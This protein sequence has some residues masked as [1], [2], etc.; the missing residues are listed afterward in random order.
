MK[1]VLI[2]SNSAGLVSDFLENDI[3]ILKNMG[4]EIDCACNML[5]KGKNSDYFFKYYGVK[6]I[7]ISFPIRN[8]EIKN[9]IKTY[10]KLRIVLDGTKYDLIHCH[11]TIAA[12][13]ARQCAKKMRIGGTKIIYTSHGF[14]FYKGND[15]I[16]SKIF[17][18]IEKYYSNYTDVII[19][20]CKEDF[21]NAK[22]MKCNNV[23]LMHGVGVDVDKF[24][25]TQI[26]RA[27]YREKLGFLPSDKVVLA[28]G[29]LNANKNHQIVIRALAE[30]RDE[31]IVFAICGREVTEKGKK[32]ELQNLADSLNVKVK[33]LG[34]RKDI[35]EI[36][37]LA[38]V[39][40][41]S[42]FKE[43][44]G[45]SGIEMLASGL[46]VV[47]SARQGIKDYVVDNVTGYLANPEDAH[48]FAVAINKAMNNTGN[49]KIKENCVSMAKKFDIEQAY[50]TILTAYK[51]V[52]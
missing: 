24:I 17:K 2:V 8:L 32:Q 49:P 44:L 45:L 30:L 38:D 10:K 22:K 20:I 27:A 31:N 36:C 15:G 35:S 47:G 18:L 9:I 28:I 46:Q 51:K 48:S 12:V 26:D 52:I 40:V 19:T 39:G 3:R 6:T 16:K 14:P 37:H 33:F 5:F 25:N 29:E 43:G 7:D 1:K 34:F 13:I 42:S 50:E 21:E 4:Y 41:L 11:S 23:F